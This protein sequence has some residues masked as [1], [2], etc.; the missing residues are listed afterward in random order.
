[1]HIGEICNL[2]EVFDCVNYEILLTK[3]RFCGFLRQ[4]LTSSDSYLGDRE[5][6]TEIK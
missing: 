3:L 2:A 1:M 5:Q 4:C 6:K